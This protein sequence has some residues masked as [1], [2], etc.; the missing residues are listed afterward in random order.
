MKEYSFDLVYDTLLGEIHDSDA[1]P[2]VENAFEDG[3]ECNRLYN[4]MFEAYLRLCHRLGVRDDD[5]DADIMIGN[6]MRT[7]RILCEKMFYYGRVFGNE[8]DGCS[9]G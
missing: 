3:G 7:Q 5:Q 1:V 4:D 9:K 2:G 6:L 8:D